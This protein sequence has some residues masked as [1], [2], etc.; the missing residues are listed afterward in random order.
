MIRGAPFVFPVLALVCGC[1]AGFTLGPGCFD[2]TAPLSGALAA[3]ALALGGRVGGTS[4]AF[5]LGLL[6][7]WGRPESAPRPPAT[8]DTDRPVIMVGRLT[9]DWRR[10]AYGWRSRLRVE[11]IRQGTRVAGWSR[12]VGVA[13]AGSEKPPDIKSFRVRGYLHRSARLLNSLDARAGVWTLRIKSPVLIDA[14]AERDRFFLEKLVD[15]VERRLERGLRELP[16]VA[17]ARV[18]EALVLGRSF[19]LGRERKQQLRRLGLSH[20]FAVSGLHV[21]LL[22]ALLHPFA[23]RLP[24]TLRVLLIVSLVGGY[25]LLTGA[26]PATIRAALM[27]SALLLS[28]SVRRPSFA[29]HALSMAVALMVVWSPAVVSDLGFQLSVSAT[30]GILCLGPALHG[31]WRRLPHFLSLPLGASIGAQLGS[32]PWTWSRFGLVHPAAPLLNLIAIPWLTAVLATAF[33]WASL[34]LID[35]GISTLFGPVL[36]ILVMPISLFEALPATPFITWPVDLDFPTAVLAAAVLA[37]VLIL[38]APAFVRAGLALVFLLVVRGPVPGPD[39]ELTMFDVGQ[40][41]ALLLRDGRHAMMIDGGGWGE[42][43]IASATL[44]RT[45]A[46]RGIRALDGALLTHGDLDHCRG[47]RDLATYIPM[48]PI[49][50]AAAVDE[51]ECVL[52]LSRLRS[53]DLREVEA[54]EIYSLG[55]W[56]IRILH[57]PGTSRLRGNDRSLVVG[58]EG[59]GQS[60]LL[61]GDIEAGAERDLRL[62]AGGQLRANILKVAHHGSDTSSGAGFLAA[63]SPALALVSAGP[64][65]RY[66]HPSEEVVRRLSLAGARVLRTDRDGM[67]TIEF[68]NPGRMLIR[69]RGPR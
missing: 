7:T 55:R 38:R 32:S 43:D 30:S 40:G 51:S 12:E 41:D 57:P 27:A 16:D 23:G 31:R 21:A 66:G 10:D 29:L 44:L 68:W 18:L 34:C 14:R 5:A 39:G 35:P 58:V 6:I 20:L 64:A 59:F 47:L 42:G 13:L 36:A 53:S 67:I 25:T 46:S 28:L 9:G 49:L 63:V 17:S 22:A 8:I 11:H 61:T 60:I 37:G 69:T 62:R 4:A 50:T 26:R 3:A 2:V 65:N 48:G 15:P 56:T 33:A 24:P 54:G 1:A 52:D 19:A 45:L